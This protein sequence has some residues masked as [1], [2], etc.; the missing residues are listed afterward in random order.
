MG[1]KNSKKRPQ[2]GSSSTSTGGGEGQ[3][4]SVRKE[5]LAELEEKGG[6]Q[7]LVLSKEEL[8]FGL[9]D[10]A[11]PVR[12]TMSDT[13]TLTNNSARK[14]KFRFDPIP[15]S[16]CKL[17]FEP[18]TGS[19]DKKKN[20]KKIVAKLVLLEPAS[21][22]F[23]VNLRILGGE[24]LFLHVRVHADQGVYGVDPTTLEL[25]ED[26]GFE[27]PTILVQMKTALKDKN[28]LLQEGIFRLA[29]D[30]YEMKR[31]KENMNKEKNF[32]DTDVDPNTIANL[33]K[34]SFSLSFAFIFLF[35]STNFK[36]IHKVWF[37]EMPTPVL[38]VL[39][40]ETIFNSGEQ[41]VCIE[42]YLDLPEPQA[43][44]LGW[45]LNLL[46]EVASQKAINKMT[47]QN[48]CTILSLAFPLSPYPLL[49]FALSF[50]Y[51]CCFLFSSP[52][53]SIFSY[54]S[55]KAIVVAPNLYD[56]PGS[57]PMEGLVMSQKAVQF[58]HNVLV[59]EMEE[60]KKR[61]RT[62]GDAASTTRNE[63]D[64]WDD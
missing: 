14:I 21:L 31:I 53:D 42:A 58:L 50:L 12:E 1:A 7:D 22:N 47:E 34:V 59:Y 51:S 16:A 37:R 60:L 38:N 55:I 13:F 30:A 46:T 17:T 6:R 29:G 56:P 19:L 26:A 2:E 41:S 9:G 43:S 40:T 57:N 64:E 10:G 36:K 5:S 23:R 28:A 4:T 35:F 11:C 3:V 15:T 62:V 27:V 24:T 45:L 39:P 20:T 18:S 48:L 32:S 54:V 61:G 8:D 63:D 52:S 44:L 25:T 49:V 33:I